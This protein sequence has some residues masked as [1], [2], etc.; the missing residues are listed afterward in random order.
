MKRILLTL[1][2]TSVPF[3]AHASSWHGTSTTYGNTTYHNFRS[4]GIQVI[5]AAEHHYHHDNGAAVAGIV[6]LGVFAGALLVNGISSCINAC[7]RPAP[8]YQQNNYYYWNTQTQQYEYW[9]Y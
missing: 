2:I 5:P 7:K 1:L 8:I 9:S 6:V 4:S 3:A